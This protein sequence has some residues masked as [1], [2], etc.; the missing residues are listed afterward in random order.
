MVGRNNVLVKENEMNTIPFKIKD[1]IFTLYVAR[2]AKVF[3]ITGYVRDI[4]D[5]MHI[6]ISL[7]DLSLNSIGGWFPA[8]DLKL[9]A[10]KML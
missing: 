3:N 5:A 9:I 7:V 1:R 10:R 2:D 4:S 6:S 8:N